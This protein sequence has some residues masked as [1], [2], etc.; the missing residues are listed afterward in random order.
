MKLFVTGGLGFIGSNFIFHRSAEHGDSIINYDIETY[1]ADH[2]NM[3]GIPSVCKDYRWIKGDI[4]NYDDVY[5]AMSGCDVVIHFAAES[6]VDNSI[7]DS[8]L[9]VD[10]NVLGTQVLLEAAKKRNIKR[11]VH[12]STDEVYGDI[13]EGESKETDITLPNN[14]YSASKLGAEALVRAYHKTHGLKTI[15]TRCTNNYGPRQH[16]EKFLPMIIT[17]ALQNKTI[18]IYG[19]GTQ[20][21]EW[22]YVSDHC[23]GISLALQYALPGTVWNFGSKVR[24]TNIDICLKVLRALGKPASLIRH[25]EDRIGHDLRYALDSYSARRELGFNNSVDFDEGLKLTI[26]WY[27]SKGEKK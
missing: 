3:A 16:Q 17:N 8:S 21:R 25:V 1:A 2:K 22:I 5:K 20:E 14:P 19:T 11:F 4:R 13:K 15:I 18:P 6:H 27:K 26:D 10:T 9:F 7:N 12:I 24:L 23:K